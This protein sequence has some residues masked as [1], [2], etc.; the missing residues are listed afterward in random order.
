M[1]REKNMMTQSQ[2]SRLLKAGMIV[3]GVL[4]LLF[5]FTPSTTSI[6]KAASGNSVQ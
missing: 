2:R 5:W 4:I 6:P 3:V 1:N